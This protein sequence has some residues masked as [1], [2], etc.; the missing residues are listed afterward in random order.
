MY[1]LSPLYRLRDGRLALQHRPPGVKEVPGRRLQVGGLH[2]HADAAQEAL[3]L[4]RLDGTGGRTRR[5]DTLLTHVREDCVGDRHLNEG[6][7]LVQGHVGRGDVQAQPWRLL[8]LQAAG[9]LPL[10]FSHLLRPPPGLPAARRQETTR[11]F[12]FRDSPS[13]RGAELHH[14]MAL[15]FSFR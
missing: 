5:Q 3:S 12:A 4:R 8:P 9:A 14:K 6:G 10:W 2:R 1:L 11:S 7:G 13:S 15:M